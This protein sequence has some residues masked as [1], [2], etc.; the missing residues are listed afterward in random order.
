[1]TADTEKISL[2]QRPSD[3]G[4]PAKHV[5]HEQGESSPAGTA[6]KSRCGIPA[7]SFVK[8]LM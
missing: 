2:L 1:M 6:R 3:V 7:G 4:P 8:R 5:M